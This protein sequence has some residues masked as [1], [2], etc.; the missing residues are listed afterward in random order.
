MEL[1]AVYSAAHSAEFYNECIRSHIILYG[2]CV[3]SVTKRVFLSEYF[4]FPL[5]VSSTSA[6]Y[7][8][9]RL[10]PMPYN[11]NNRHRC[12]IKHKKE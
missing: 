1:E 11:L 4:G 2:T 5:S 7:S 9:T 8:F 12:Y 10:S 6:L 3:Q